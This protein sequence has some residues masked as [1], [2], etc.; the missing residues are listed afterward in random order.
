MTVPPLPITI[1]Q[2]QPE[3]EGSAILK[4]FAG[5]R[6]MEFSPGLSWISQATGE[7]GLT[8]SRAMSLILI[9]P[10]GRQTFYNG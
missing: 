8:T 9:F 4:S 10:S 7:P 6:P 5:P 2:W 1:W 3:T